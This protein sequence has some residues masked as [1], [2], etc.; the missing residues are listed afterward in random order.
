MTR[1]SKS[2]AMGA[3]L[4]RLGICALVLQARRLGWLRRGELTIL[5]YHRIAPDPPDAFEPAD[6]NVSC[7][8]E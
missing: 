8:A 7:S 1:V 5:G 4:R 6:D 3:V 2:A